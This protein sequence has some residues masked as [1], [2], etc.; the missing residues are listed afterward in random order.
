MSQIQNVKR[1][2]QEYIH[3]VNKGIDYIEKNIHSRLSLES[4]SRAAG[5]SS[6]HFH[7]IFKAIIGETLN[8]FIN[9]LRLEKAASMLLY[10]PSYTMTY[11]A[12]SCG[13]SSPAIFSRSFKDHYGFS[14]TSYRDLNHHK[15]SKNSKIKSKD[16][17][18]SVSDQLYI[19]D[20]ASSI[21]E[22]RSEMDVE[23]RK[24]PEMEVAYI[25]NIG[26][27]V[28]D[29]GIFE[30]LFKRL[31]KWAGARDL[32]SPDTRFLSVYYEDPK[33]TDEDKLRM[34]VCMTV[35]KGTKADG[36]VG[37]QKLEA[38][39]YAVTR[40]EIKEPCEYKE[41]WDSVYRNWLPESGYQPDNKPSYEI[42]QN[43]Q[44]EHPEGIQ[45]VDICV[46]VKPL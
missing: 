5:F 23:V 34:D 25:R 18:E 21:T 33:I 17:K 22:R 29:S 30:K 27:Y 15:N 24:I 46:P 6:F 37:I 31:C 26:A 40:F 8:K 16:G 45:I 35:P 10:N 39:K 43:D 38:G 44:K 42:Y 4:I 2:R 13:F 7:R 12:I 20:I 41:A 11:I 32:F 19:D 9:R 28:G 1:L 3:R 14:P 36:E